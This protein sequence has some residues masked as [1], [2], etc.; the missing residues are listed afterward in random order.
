ML[1]KEFIIKNK[2]Y[3]YDIKLKPKRGDKR[4]LIY[5]LIDNDDIV[6]VGQSKNLNQRLSQHNKLIKY[7]FIYYIHTNETELLKT[8]ESYIKAFTPIK[9]IIKNGWNNRVV[10]TKIDTG[11]YKAIKERAVSD[12][13]NIADI[14]NKS[15]GDY[16]NNY[17]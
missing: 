2:I 16:L 14:I 11:L 15:L 1:S 13:I 4:P 6:Y 8:E 17:L 7:D 12:K 5:F 10:T 9:N 3:R